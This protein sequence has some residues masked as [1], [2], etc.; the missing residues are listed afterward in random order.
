MRILK[1]GIIL[2]LPLMMMGIYFL[3]GSPI[4]A[5]VSFG[6]GGF[7]LY[8]YRDP[9]RSVCFIEGALLSPADGTVVQ[10]ERRA[11][12]SKGICQ[13]VK[14]SIFLSLFDAHVNRSPIGCQLDTKHYYRGKFLPAFLSKAGLRNEKM[15]Y[16]LIDKNGRALVVTQIAGFIARRIVSFVNDGER[17]KQG[18]KIGFIRFGSRVEMIIP[19]SYRLQVK[20]G[21][22]VRAGESVVAIYKDT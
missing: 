5:L 11:D 9:D 18:Q 15:D 12:G 7:I 6:I 16:N 21:Q 22:K 4:K 8:F 10:I 19:N 1:E 17:V 2:A 20:E 3:F 13:G 14:V